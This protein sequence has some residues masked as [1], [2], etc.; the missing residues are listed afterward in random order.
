MAEILKN[1]DGTESA[2]RNKGVDNENSCQIFCMHIGGSGH[3]I[4]FRL[5]LD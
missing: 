5:R 2:E 3:G 4:D 1:D